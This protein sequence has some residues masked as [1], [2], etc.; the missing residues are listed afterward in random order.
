[1][2]E[3]RVT[4]WRILSVKGEGGVLRQLDLSVATGE[5]TIVEAIEDAA[6]RAGIELE[7]LPS[8]DTGVEGEQPEGGK[9]M[10]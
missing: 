4:R 10:R 9:R 2:T 3:G 7:R 1:M 6:R 8:G 5:G